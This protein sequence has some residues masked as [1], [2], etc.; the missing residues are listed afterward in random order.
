MTTRL[1]RRIVRGT[2]GGALVELAVSVPLLVLILAGTVDFG[3]V[4]YTSIAL[5][6]AARAGAQWG[7]Y[8]AANS[9]NATT[10]QTTAVGAIS[11]N[12]GVTAV[13]ARNCF[14]AL[15]DGSSFTTATCT[16]TCASGRHMVINVTVTARKDFSLIMNVI[17]GIGPSIHLE[18]GATLRVVN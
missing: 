7:A 2:A 16:S 6:N 11:P 18:R 17:P 12:T 5:T 8:S 15:D 13:A 3:R 4:F 14:C 10:M 9:G 1:L